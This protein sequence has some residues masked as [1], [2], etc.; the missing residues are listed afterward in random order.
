MASFADRL[1][2]VL[3]R[4][5]D[6][7]LLS[8]RGIGNEIGFYVFDYPPERELE[9]RQR[10]SDIMRDIARQRPELRVVNV[11]LFD[12]IIDHLE[13]RGL[14]SKAIE[15][16]R[17]RGDD[18]LR[19]ALL[20]PLHAERL[21]GVFAARFPPAN[22]DLV[23]LSGI[24]SAYPL[25]RSHSLLNTLHAVMNGIPLVM[26]FPGGYDGTNLRLFNQLNDENYYRAFKLIP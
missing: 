23:L 11:N 12:L 25:I 1:N 5:L 13:E 15:M 2:A 4:L 9:V 26:F 3:P 16:Q 17:S 6:A 19:S 20:A 14:L 8:G 7:D 24:G 21:A 18:A 10:L 22:Y